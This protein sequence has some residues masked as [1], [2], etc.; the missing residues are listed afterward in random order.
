MITAVYL[1]RLVLATGGSASSFDSRCALIVLVIRIT[2][3]PTSHLIFSSQRCV[4]LL[5]L[6]LLRDAISRTERVVG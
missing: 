5:L 2:K 3:R 6:R 4:L 1:R